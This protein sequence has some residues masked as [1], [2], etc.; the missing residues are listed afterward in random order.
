MT[1]E[2]ILQTTDLYSSSWKSI[3]RISTSYRWEEDTC[4][5]KNGYKN[6]EDGNIKVCRTF[7]QKINQKRKVVETVNE[8]LDH[9]FDFS[10]LFPSLSFMRNISTT[11]CWQSLNLYYHLPHINFPFYGPLCSF[12][13]LQI[14]IRFGPP[15]IHNFFWF[16]N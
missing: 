9:A 6:L 12:D 4:Q 10:P 1:H 11:S 7:F 8:H 14:L 5:N 13:L 15:S 2:K 3:Y 16:N